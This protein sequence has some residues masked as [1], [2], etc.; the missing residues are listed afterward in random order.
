MFHPDYP[1][2]VA[3]KGPSSMIQEEAKM[4]WC[5]HHPNVVRPFA[6]VKC[7]E[8][9]HEQRPVSLLVMQRLG[10]CLQDFL[11]DDAVPR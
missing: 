11:G 1:N 8:L 7:N 9:D 10:D 5:L 3:K 4:M 2:C 6:I